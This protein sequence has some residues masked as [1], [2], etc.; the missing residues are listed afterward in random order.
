MIKSIGVYRNTNKK[1]NRCNFGYFKMS[2]MRLIW[3][4]PVFLIVKS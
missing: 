2:K 1:P 4:G 3:L